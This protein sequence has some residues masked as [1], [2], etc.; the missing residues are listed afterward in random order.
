MKTLNGPPKEIKKLYMQSKYLMLA[1]CFLSLLSC[2]YYSICKLSK[3]AYII[4]L[5]TDELGL[6]GVYKN[7]VD[8]T[9]YWLSAIAQ[10]LFYGDWSLKILKML[11]ITYN[12]TMITT[13]ALASLASAASA[14]AVA[15]NNKSENITIQPFDLFNQISGLRE[16]NLP[17]IGFGLAG[18]F[19]NLYA[20][21]CL[22]ACARAL[23]CDKMSAK[24][25]FF[26]TLFGPSR[27][28]HALG[29]ET[30]LDSRAAEQASVAQSLQDLKSQPETSTRAHSSLITPLPEGESPP[31]L[32]DQAGS[33]ALATPVP[34]RRQNTQQTT[35][36]SCHERLSACWNNKKDR[37]QTDTELSEPLLPSHRSGFS[38]VHDRTI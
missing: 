16:N 26:V 2:S 29:I 24:Q 32:E 1:I 18:T 3:T 30:L 37:G 6:S 36:C 20:A 23:F 17:D 8:N 21:L 4:N 34:S 5:L 33:G 12:K 25:Q 31:Y 14:F 9:L 13:A 19:L 15:S 10:Q 27:I 22:L 7:V 38:E 28:T 35:R 11:T